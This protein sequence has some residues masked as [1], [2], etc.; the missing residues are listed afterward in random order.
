MKKVLNSKLV[1]AWQVAF[2]AK[3]RFCLVYEDEWPNTNIY[4]QC[5]LVIRNI[6]ARDLLSSF[7]HCQIN[8]TQFF[9]NTYPYSSYSLEV[10]A[11]LVYLMIGTHATETEGRIK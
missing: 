2:T 1:T 6:F 7:S 9:N 8:S 10:S 5:K 11:S 4:R 3:E